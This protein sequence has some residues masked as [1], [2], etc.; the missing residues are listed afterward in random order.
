MPFFYSTQL[1]SQTL[2]PVSSIPNQK[3]E[4]RLAEDTAY[5]PNMRIANLGSH[6]ASS[7]QHNPIAGVYACIKHIRLLSNGVELDAMRH[8]NRYLAFKNINDT[9]ERNRAVNRAVA[10]HSLGYEVKPTDHQVSASTV[11]ATGTSADEVNQGH[12][13]LRK[14]LPLMEQ[15]PVID[16]AVFKNCVIQVEFESRADVLI[17]RDNV[18]QT[19]NAPI[20]IAEE[21]TSP[22]LRKSLTSS[23]QGAVYNKIEHDV[24]IVPDNS[25][26]V[27]GG[28]GDK[29]EQNVVQRLN[30]FDDKYVSR[31]LMSK[32]FADKSKYVAGNIV[33][34]FG[35]FGSLAPHK[36]AINVRLNG[37]N[38]FP[39][40]LDKPSTRDMLLYDTFGKVNLPP[41][42]SVECVGSDAPSGN[43][44]NTQGVPT[45]EANKQSSLVGNTAFFGMGLNAKV[46]DLTIDYKRTSLNNAL[47]DDKS[48]DAM[49]VHVYAEVRKSLSLKNGGYNIAYL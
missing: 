5:Y 21:I 1:K 43:S 16:T 6:G 2:D 20:L 34:G 24:F 39:Q 12:I 31:I 9:N 7:H 47:A 13:D 10:K 42:G 11:F 8:A 46:S 18:P 25:A 35:Q 23:F 22:S 19:V 45:L 40:H 41:Y 38:V 26:Q 32:C 29:D 48:A 30:A 14:A 4:F 33:L 37:A 49:E 28:V 27:A 3:V 44:V 36:E 17:T 15:M